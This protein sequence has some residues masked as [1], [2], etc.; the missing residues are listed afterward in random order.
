MLQKLADKLYLDCENIKLYPAT[1]FILSEFSSKCQC[2][3]FSFQTACCWTCV[4]CREDSIVAREDLCLKCTH[5][6][7]AVARKDGS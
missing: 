4:A 6:E 2:D 3:R 7:C 5:G 1:Y